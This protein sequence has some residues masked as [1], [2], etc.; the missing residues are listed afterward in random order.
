MDI[1]SIGSA[2]RPDY[3]QA[4]A[5][6][7]ASLP[8]VRAF[9]PVT[10]VNDTDATCATDLT[11]VQYQAVVDFCKTPTQQSDTRVFRL[12]KWLFNP[13][14]Y[15]HNTSGWLCAQK[16]P[17]EAVAQLLRGYAQTG[18]TFP[19]YLVIVDDDSYIA[20]MSSLVELLQAHPP[21]IPVVAATLPFTFQGFTFP[22]GGYGSFL[23]KAAL[24]NMVHP[25]DCRIQH[26]WFDRR[27]Q[28]ACATLEWNA[29]G[30]KRFFRNGMSVNDLMY[31]YSA[32][33]PFVQSL[34]WREMGFCM[35]SDHALAY[36]INSYHVA[37]ADDEPIVIPYDR[38]NPLVTRHG[39][40][41]L[42]GKV[43]KAEHEQCAGNITFCHY[44]EPSIMFSRFAEL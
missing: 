23:T 41:S 1:L 32:Q 42:D 43:S 14:L 8:A 36:F 12:M 3:L 44:V 4:Q 26:W 10:E 34:H 13:T 35:H 28:L 2:M 18:N 30:E 24:Q 11:P 5:Q 9:Y 21:N 38:Q 27:S 29:L 40:T 39:Y 15:N 20:N 7:F 22:W 31:E 37:L 19:D 6:T 17:V 33:Q 16:R 25:I